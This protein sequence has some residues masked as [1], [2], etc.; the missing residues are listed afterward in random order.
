MD[1]LRGGA[2]DDLVS[3]DV[4]TGPTILFLHGFPFDRRMWSSVVGALSGW[5]RIALDLPGFGDSPPAPA[6]PTLSDWAARVW[7]HLD[8][9]DVEAPVVVVGLS[10]GG[11]LAFELVR[12]SPGRVRGLVLMDTRAEADT[13]TARASRDAMAAH[14]RQAGAEA[15]AEMLLPRLLAPEATP[16]VVD[17]LRAMMCAVP[18]DTIVAALEAMRDRR[19]NSPMLPE[20]G[21]LPVLVLGGEHDQLTPPAD[22]RALADRI[23][24]SRYAIIAGAGHVPP[25]EQPRAVVELLRSW[26]EGG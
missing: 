26:L 8:Q 18:A 14:A 25:L 3:D 9:L 12:H 19:D 4:G 10:M 7:R 15:I 21:R 24:G 11:Y 16:E 5:R 17:A 2:L 20:L 23:P 6:R 22:L 13:E 1:A